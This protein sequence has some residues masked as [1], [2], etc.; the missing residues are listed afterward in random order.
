MPQYRYKARDKEGALHTGTMEAPR[1]EAVAD[2]L[3]LNG[4]IPVQIE[5]YAQSGLLQADLLARLTRVSHQDLIIF[6]RQLA[7]LMGAGI[8]FMQSLATIERQVENPR[9]KGIIAEIK[10]DI[11]AGLPFSEALA[12]HPRVFSKLYVS[13]V[14]AGETAGILDDILNRLALLLEHD[15]E[16]RAR[17]KTAVR[18]PLIVVA[19]IS[20]AF[21]FLVTFVIPKFAVIFARF[22][23]QLPL[24]TRILIG[25]N[26]VF[27]HYWYLV[28]LGGALLVAGVIWYLRTPGGRWQW[29]GL[30]LKLP[31][32]GVLFQKVAL[33]RFARV[34][35][36]MQKSGLSMLLT[37]D[38]VAE[39][40]GNVVISRVV[41]QMRESLRQ[42]K[43]LREPMEAS[44]IFPPLL[45]QMVA[46]GEEAGNLDV[47][48]NKVSDYYD[49]DVDYA[50]R[51]LSTMIEPILLLFVGGMVLF[52]ALGIFLP[53]WNM[54]SLFKK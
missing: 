27:H 49:M 17:V 25:I 42:G 6:S 12:R 14:R 54:I 47:M 21:V 23:T 52:L 9:L 32:F 36:A 22:K 7:T 31:V 45:V 33:S 28:L 19:A 20:A 16:T 30:K 13:M 50:L 3:S 37:L 1:K 48:L 46:V 43:T 2:Q 40:V 51:N 11:E 8:S 4:Y 53:M 38:I 34:F 44:D 35:G 10:R 26:T 39:T 5:E 29:D 41:E 18:Y 15:A 24:P